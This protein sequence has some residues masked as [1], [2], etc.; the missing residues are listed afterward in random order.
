VPVPAAD[1]GY[2]YGPEDY[3]AFVESIEPLVR[4][5]PSGNPK[6]DAIDL[7]L[8][9]RKSHNLSPPAKTVWLDCVQSQYFMRLTW[10]DDQCEIGDPAQSGQR[11]K[12]LDTLDRQFLRAALLLTDPKGPAE[13]GTF[14]E[15]NRA[16]WHRIVLTTQQGFPTIVAPD[17]DLELDNRELR[18][19]R[20][21][22][23]CS[24]LERR[25]LTNVFSLNFLPTA[26]LE[27]IERGTPG[28]PPRAP[29]PTRG[30]GGVER[31]IEVEEPKQR[32]IQ[33]DEPLVP[34]YMRMV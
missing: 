9:E 14:G 1:P 2:I 17:F 4:S 29:T 18:H 7:I 28:S 30:T 6:A 25:S 5:K 15:L 13:R 31:Q 33:Y 10:K 26:K 8:T 20:Y 11:R 16:A 32:E 23:L 19:L 12:H 21:L 3:F 24:D 22:G 34:R 27:N